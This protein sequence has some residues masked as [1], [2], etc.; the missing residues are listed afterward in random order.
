MPLL[1]PRKTITVEK[2]FKDSQNRSIIELFKFFGWT[3]TPLYGNLDQLKPKTDT[4]LYK[5][6]QSRPMIVSFLIF[7]DGPWP[8]LAYEGFR[9]Y[10]SLLP[11]GKDFFLLSSLLG[12]TNT[13]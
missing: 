1:K 13:F 11:C 9:H 8:T 7:P 6:S 5:N 12:R 2:L 4:K 10:K 3:T